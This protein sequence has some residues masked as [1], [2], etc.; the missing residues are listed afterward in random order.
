MIGANMITIPK[1]PFK[2]DV[3]GGK[4]TVIQLRVT[5]AALIS[6]RILAFNPQDEYRGIMVNN[7][8]PRVLKAQGVP[9]VRVELNNGLEIRHSITDERGYFEFQ[10]VYPGRAVVTV[11]VAGI[12]QNYCLLEDKSEVDLDPAGR[13]NMLF[14]FLPQ[15]RS[16][17]I[18]E[19]DEI[20]EEER[21]LG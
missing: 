4:E 9:D 21:V 15:E 10:E 11:S 18:L 2:V 5:E 14:K 7:D 17:K 8:E 12:P 6:G 19:T 13:S 20:V 1:A 16:I 3:S